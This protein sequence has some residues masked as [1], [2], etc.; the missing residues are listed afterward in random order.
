MTNI[1]KFIKI[2]KYC[3][4][5]QSFQVDIRVQNIKGKHDNQLNLLKMQEIIWIFK[6]CFSWPYHSYR[7]LGTGNKIFHFISGEIVTS[8]EPTVISFQK[9]ENSKENESM[10]ENWMLGCKLVFKPIYKIS[11]SAEENRID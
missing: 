5:I 2:K 8:L 1:K 11:H 4:L 3:K 10:W 7:D 9:I 6:N